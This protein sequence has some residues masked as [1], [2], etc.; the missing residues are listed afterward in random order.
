[1]LGVASNTWGISGTDFLLI[2]GALCFACFAAVWLRRS[3]LTQS[4]PFS[5]RYQ[6]GTC[7]LAMLN[8]G[9]DLAGMVAAAALH[10]TSALAVTPNRKLDIKHTPKSHASALERELFELLANEPAPSIRKLK[11]RLTRGRAIR[12]IQAE[13]IREG[14]MIDPRRARLLAQLW[15]FGVPLIGLGIARLIAGVANHKPIGDLTVLVCLVAVVMFMFARDRPH[16]TAAGES[17]LDAQRIKH[18]KWQSAGNTH[19]DLAIALFGT[20]A[21]WALDPQLAAAWRTSR[22]WIGNWRDAYLPERAAMWSD[23][24]SF[25]GGGFGDGGGG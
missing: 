10:R 23:T 20:P 18:R 12:Q 24:G 17:V 21:V 13:L 22:P 5:K 6:L 16:A 1:M 8:G 2:Y 15:Q 14:L 7:E 25:G 9:A 3:Q 19:P 11:R 4:G